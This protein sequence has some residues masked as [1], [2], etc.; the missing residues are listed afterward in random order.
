MSKRDKINILDTMGAKRKR[1]SPALL[2][3]KKIVWQ[4]QDQMDALEFKKESHSES[5]QEQEERIKDD[6][7]LKFFFTE[8]K[9]IERE[10]FALKKQYILK[11]SEDAERAKRVP[12]VIFTFQNMPTHIDNTWVMIPEKI[13]TFLLRFWH[14]S[15]KG[16]KQENSQ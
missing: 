13:L 9:E 7:I 6:I 1:K 10:S 14:E 12:A 4:I 2:E 15:H 8:Y 3:A 16:D 11:A 5:P